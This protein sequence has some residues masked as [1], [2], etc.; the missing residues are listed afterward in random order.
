MEILAICL[1]IA[2][3]VAGIALFIYSRICRN[4]F[5]KNMARTHILI[6]KMQ[7]RAKTIA[8]DKQM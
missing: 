3:V 8:T 2:L 6:A 4:E 5:R 7:A 1:I